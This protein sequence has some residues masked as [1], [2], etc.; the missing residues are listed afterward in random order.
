MQ[1]G[2]PNLA[3]L[4]R[5]LAAAA[6]AALLPPAARATEGASLHAVSM[7]S[8]SP[9]GHERTLDWRGWTAKASF[10]VPAGLEAQNLR[11]VLSATPAETGAA[12]HAWI[13]VRLNGSEAAVLRPEP[14]PFSAQV[15]FP[16]QYLRSGRNEAEIRF[17]S[18]A[19]ACPAPEDGAWVLDLA[20]SQIELT[21]LDFRPESPAGLDAL[22]RSEM[23]SPR[24]IHIS[25][26]GMD[27][28]RAAAFQ[29]WA[30]LALGVRAPLTPRFVDAPAAADLLVRFVEDPAA[31]AAFTFA[32]GAARVVEVRA[33]SVE[34]ALDL[35]RVYA[36]SGARDAWFTIPALDPAWAP[37]PAHSTF[38]LDRRPDRLALR[39][40][41]DTGPGAAGVT[42]GLSVNGRPLPPRS[43]GDRAATI[44][45]PPDL[46][47]PGLNRIAIAP[48]IAPSAD[49]TLCPGRDDAPPARLTAL[50]LEPGAPVSGAD[51]FGLAAGAIAPGAHLVLP[52]ETAADRSA[53]LRLLVQIARQSGRIPDV[54]GVSESMPRGA[55]AIILIAPR[56]AIPADILAA[57][58]VSLQAVLRGERPPPRL[59]LGAP[60]MAA[61]IGLAPVA[62]GAAIFESPFDPEAAITLVT[63]ADGA[64]FPATIDYLV[65]SGMLSAFDGRV[66]R[67]TRDEF[68]VQDRGPWR[69]APL[70]LL[71]PAGR[72]ELERTLLFL[73]VIGGLTLSWI[74]VRAR[75]RRR[76]M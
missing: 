72:Q 11:I 38:Y 53:Q 42:L 4:A 60:A 33:P 32:P 3:R 71:P 45:I 39:M 62:G 12:P 50:R 67:W 65:D 6:V 26:A 2:R 7:Q 16:A 5:A 48:V 56:R 52:A 27:P 74:M 41:M 75:S 36:E 21:T 31:E 70:R 46:L 34:S 1:R 35:L 8:L 15:D 54:F 28:D 49:A 66:V 22:L 24:R 19:G 18:P 20:A 58:P 51:L 44:S 69:A 10:S 13:E 59:R 29:A 25:P 55:P 17:V 76:F 37:E 68:G 63:E 73:S 9:S 40:A 30:A 23:L 43:V 64:S 57:A 47:V 14:Y 61:D